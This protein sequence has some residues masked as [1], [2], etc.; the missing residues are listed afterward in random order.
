M[1][2]IPRMMNLALPRIV[3]CSTSACITAFTMFFIAS[4][5]PS[6]AADQTPVL[7]AGA[8]ADKI[9]SFRGLHFGD[10]LDKVPKEWDLQPASQD[11]T[12]DAPLKSYIRNEEEKRLGSIDLQEIVYFFVNNKFYAVEMLTSDRTQTEMLRLALNHAYGTPSSP[13]LQDDSS[14][15][16]GKKVSAQYC[17]NRGTGEGRAL[18]FDNEL[19]QSYEKTINDV[20]KKAAARF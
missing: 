13:P 2:H 14:V 17:M 19:Q 9:D 7:E 6:L 16:L 15:W 4:P 12:P 3:A 11:A 18:M 20:A 10:T 1:N 5:N 8:K